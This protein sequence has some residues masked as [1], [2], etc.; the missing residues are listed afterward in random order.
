MRERTVEQHI[1]THVIGGMKRIVPKKKI[2]LHSSLA[3]TETVLSIWCMSVPQKW[4]CLPG[5]N[6]SRQYH[7]ATEKSHLIYDHYQVPF[8][9]HLF[10]DVNIL[11]Y[12]ILFYF[13]YASSFFYCRCVIILMLL[14]MSS[15]N[16][17]Y[18]TLEEPTI[19]C[20]KKC[21]SGSKEI[22]WK[23]WRDKANWF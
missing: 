15:T 9:Y 19:M 11:V 1:I 16:A 12:C 6:A 17:Q 8:L 4:V 22:W 7:Y 2:T 3:N 10:R 14:L 21:V 18:A 23:L 5:S 20:Y 13:L